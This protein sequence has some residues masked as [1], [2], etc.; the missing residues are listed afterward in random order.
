MARRSKMEVQKQALRSV[1]EQG[2]R[3]A[4]AKN[5]GYQIPL[6]LWQDL[7][8]EVARRKRLGLSYA[9]QNAIAVVGI[10]EWLLRNKGVNE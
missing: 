3:F 2:T 1:P 8:D 6:P 4:P 10:Q 9:S 5:Q 7:V